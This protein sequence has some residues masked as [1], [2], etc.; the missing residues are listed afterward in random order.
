MGHARETDSR[1]RVYLFLSVHSELDLTSTLRA[2]AHRSISLYLEE[3]SDTRTGMIR[4]HSF[5]HR[6]TIA[7][8]DLPM[9][10]VYTPDLPST[11][12]R[13]AEAVVAGA[14]E[15][16]RNPWQG[17]R[18][19]IFVMMTGALRAKFPRSSAPAGSSKLLGVERI[20][21]N[22]Q[23]SRRHFTRT[24]SWA[25]R[26]CDSLV[27]GESSSFS[28]ATS[29]ALRSWMRTLVRCSLGATIVALV[30]SEQEGIEGD[31]RKVAVG[32]CQL[33]QG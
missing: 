11:L 15:E 7:R 18:K 14:E 16:N 33:L 10:W 20:S 2:G 30:I 13:H 5:I 32:K 26:R 19:C 29:T 17:T 6:R 21:E 8:P 3:S 12:L 25:S 1:C 23:R 27:P 22:P 4:W 24:W 31:S 9:T 28:W